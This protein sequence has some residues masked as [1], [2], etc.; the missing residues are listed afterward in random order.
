VSDRIKFHLDEHIWPQLAEA[1]RRHGIDVSTTN[2]V[3]LR[4]GDDIQHLA[5]AIR[6]V[7][8]I[9]T[10]DADFLRYAK[11]VSDHPGIVSCRQRG[12][13]LARRFV[14]SR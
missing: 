7:R 14:G 13:T 5:F 11:T 3:G 10:K 4:E 12:L 9:V 8:V 1:M 2:E 6:E